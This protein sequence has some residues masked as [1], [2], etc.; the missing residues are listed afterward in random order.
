MSA[1]LNAQLNNKNN[2]FIV[3]KMEIH[4][5]LPIFTGWTGNDGHFVGTLFEVRARARLV[6][7]NASTKTASATKYKLFSKFC[8]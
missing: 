4:L 7:R 6:N 3:Q 8:I 1:A 5:T 2:Y